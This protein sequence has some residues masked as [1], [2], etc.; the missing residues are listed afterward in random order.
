MTFGD[1]CDWIHPR[2]PAPSD[3]ASAPLVTI[4]ATAPIHTSRSAFGNFN[5][6][7]AAVSWPTSP[8]SEK[9][10]AAK[11]TPTARDA[12]Y[13]LISR[14]S[15]LRQ[16]TKAIA[17]KLTAVIAATSHGGRCEMNLLTYTAT[18]IRSEE[19]TSE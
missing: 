15:G 19:H 16:S 18:P 2:T 12:G 14:L 1:R 10:M 7:P 8:H 9:K 13:C 3:A 17:K 11:D 6:I 4:A 5:A